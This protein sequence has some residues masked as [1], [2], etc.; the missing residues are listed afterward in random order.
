MVII[1][2]CAW[3][4]CESDS[5]YPERLIKDGK[6][7]NFHPFPSCR[8]LKVDYMSPEIEALQYLFTCVTLIQLSYGG[9]IQIDECTFK[10]LAQTMEYNSTNFNFYLDCITSLSSES[11]AGTGWFSK[12]SASSFS[13]QKGMKGGGDTGRTG[14]SVGLHWNGFKLHWRRFILH[15]S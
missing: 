10:R 12:M 6:F 8:V 4:T 11:T 1:K 13:V 15:W 7:I 2:I 14:A 3:G 5:C 9:L